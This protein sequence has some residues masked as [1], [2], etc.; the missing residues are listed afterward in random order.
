MGKRK[1]KGVVAPATNILSMLDGVIYSELVE[2]KVINTRGRRR[3]ARAVTPTP[4]STE[5]HDEAYESF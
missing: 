2:E 5:E 4:D 3:N 1:Q